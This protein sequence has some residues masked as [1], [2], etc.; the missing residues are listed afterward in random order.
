MS[1]SAGCGCGCAARRRGIRTFAWAVALPL[2]LLASLSFAVRADAAAE[3]EGIHKIQHV[4]MIMQENRSF[5]SYFGTYP[6]ANGIPG[7]VCVPDP[8]KGGCVAPFHDSNLKNAGGNHGARAAREDI[9]GGKMDGFIKVLSQASRECKG[10]NP[11]CGCEET[12]CDEVMGYHDAREIPNYWTYAS[13]FVLQDNMFESAAS[14]SLPEH[15]FLVSGWSAVCPNG[16]SNPMDCVSSL[17]PRK[18]GV[19]QTEPW[20]DV[21]DLLYKAHVSWRYYVMEGTEPDCER[22]EAV[23]C[24]PKS[25]GSATPGIWN[26]LADFAVVKQDGQLGNIQSLDNFYTAVHTPNT[27]GL[28]SVS[29]TVPNGSVSEHPPSS[30]ASG[31]AYVTTLI[32]S[33]MRSP[34]WGST[35]IFLS[36]D[37][38]GGLYDHVVPPAIDENGYGL[39]VPG[40]VI[41]PYAKA[42]YIDHQQLSHDAYLKFIEDDFLAGERLNP[43]TDGRPDRRPDVREEAPGLGDLANDFDFNQSPQPPLLLSTHPEP[44]PAS[45]PPGPDPP[46]VET[47]SA[48]SP[49]PRG[50]TLTATV[51]PKGSAV[52]SCRFEYGTTTAYGAQVPCS[53]LPG[54][55]SSAVEV[56][57]Q[58]TGLTP[59]SVYHFR[60][61]ATNAGGTATGND[62]TFTTIEALPELG[63]CTIAPLEGKTRHGR[64]ADPACTEHS[65]GAA[66]SYEWL[67]G[68][69]RAAFT[70]TAT[71]GTAV[72][73][74]TVRKVTI[75]CAKGSGTGRYT[76]SSREQLTMTLTGCEGL[77][78][79]PARVKARSEVKSRPPP[80]KANWATSRTDSKKAPRLASSS[81]PRAAGLASRASNA[82]RGWASV[83]AFSWRVLSSGASRRSTRPWSCLPSS[84]L[85]RKATRS[86]KASKAG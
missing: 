37:D 15:L 33:I 82:A 41:S 62:Q 79:R 13:K 76:G 73:L 65:E 81:G 60:I 51:N 59:N 12:R 32:N 38:W 20:T 3:E 57:A 23:T 14:W 43:A 16:D 64:Y 31:Q 36:W 52:S 50:A 26:P 19:G 66:G 70:V 84:S 7:G 29:W 17:E 85:R 2:A 77:R 10:D 55:G 68:A 30:I 47:L 83:P 49:Q 74:E 28:P 35:A 61:D 44:G 46:A 24:K 40:L 18:L 71:G 5:D 1:T 86:R 8:M 56:S 6:G 67:P 75:T 63:R 58:V 11:E 42:G 4:V 22:D 45:K 54:K 53:V 48:S 72:K 9:D 80:S 34:C 39:R 78:K 25:Q 27:C 69:T 21:T